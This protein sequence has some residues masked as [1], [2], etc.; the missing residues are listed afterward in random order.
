MIMRLLLEMQQAGK[1]V[2]SSMSEVENAVTALGQVVV[3]EM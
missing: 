1:M 2:L 3:L